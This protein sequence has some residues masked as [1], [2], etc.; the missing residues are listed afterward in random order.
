MVQHNLRYISAGFRQLRATVYISSS[1]DGGG[2]YKAKGITTQDLPKAI[3]ALRHGPY[4]HYID[5]TACHASLFAIL[6][7]DIHGIFSWWS[8]NPRDFFGQIAQFFGCQT[9]DVK[10]LFR[11]FFTGTEYGIAKG[12]SEP[13]FSLDAARGN[14]DT[15][16]TLGPL[17]PHGNGRSIPFNILQAKRHVDNA[18]AQL[19]LRM[20]NRSLRPSLYSETV[21]HLLN[22]AESLYIYRFACAISRLHG[23]CA[24]QAI[25]HDGLLISNVVDQDDIVRIGHECALQMFGNTLPLHFEDWYALLHDKLPQQT[26]FESDPNHPGKLHVVKREASERLDLFLHKRPR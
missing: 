17:I 24:V 18:F 20:I 9:S 5:V 2:R 1:P 6:L 7:P 14:P 10:Q 8:Q 15:E 13:P 22:D 4:T 21:Q 19:K 25:V 11:K 16:L 26:F 23:V 3:R 12:F